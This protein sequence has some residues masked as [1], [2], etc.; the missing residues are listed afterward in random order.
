[1]KKSFGFLFVFFLSISLVA[2]TYNE[3]DEYAR[4][5][6]P[7]LSVLFENA[8]NAASVEY[9]SSLKKE[10]ESALSSEKKNWLKYLR[11]EGLYR[12]GINAV[13]SMDGGN[14]IIV[15]K[16]DPQDWYNVGVSLSIP[17]DDLFDRRNKV[18]RQRIRIQSI[19]SQETIAY[20]Q[21]KMDIINLYTQTKNE[22]DVL[23]LKVESLTFAKSNYKQSE[24]DFVN[25]KITAQDLSAQKELYNNA[26]MNYLNTKY[27]IEN[28]L[29][30]LE[31][32]SQ[33]NIISQ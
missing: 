10:E 26:L 8:S 13:Q 29:L 16:K 19:E 32:V 21:L 30:R 23:K 4:I 15:P 5:D 1:M 11:V 25:N 33:T 28:L 7:P 17:L 20:E 9:Y 12:Y 2:Q 18:K 6:L 3:I 22:L 24:I 27:A 14:A 31:I